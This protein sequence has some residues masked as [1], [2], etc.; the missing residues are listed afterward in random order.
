MRRIDGL[1]IIAPPIASC[2]GDLTT[3]CL[4]TGVSDVM[5]VCS[6]AQI[7]SPF[8]RDRPQDRHG[9]TAGFIEGSANHPNYGAFPCSRWWVLPIW[10]ATVTQAD[11]YGVC[12]VSKLRGGGLGSSGFAA[13]VD[14]PLFPCVNT[15]S[16]LGTII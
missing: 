4:L 1:V 5:D 15:R 2:L 11:A 9:S 13:L 16:S 8:D 7:D 14:Y 10:N 3:L 6:F 12:L